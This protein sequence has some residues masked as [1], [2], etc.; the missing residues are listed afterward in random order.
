LTRIRSLIALSACVALGA[1][2]VS[3]GGDGG[4]DTTGNAGP[5]PRSVGSGTIDFQG[6]FSV[7]QN[8]DEGGTVELHAKGP[9][10]SNGAGQTPSFDLDISGVYSN[11]SSDENYR[12][13][14]GL[15]S[16]GE[17]AFVNFPQQAPGEARGALVQGGDYE[18]D[19]PLVD[20]LR[21]KGGSL[22]AADLIALAKDVHSE[23]E[24]TIDGVPTVH[25]SG[26]FD[27]DRIV[28]ALDPILADPEGLGLAPNQAIRPGTRGYLSRFV[29]AAGFDIYLGK[30]DGF[31]RRFTAD[32]V[33]SG[34]S[35]ERVQMDLTASLEEVNEPQTI[36]APAD[37]KPFIDLITQPYVALYG[38]IVGI[39]EA[40]KYVA[41]AFDEDGSADPQKCRELLAK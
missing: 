6:K 9:F 13:D 31:P 25:L 14:F 7:V 36:E 17:E 40:Q 1:V 38:S 29:R 22:T 11:P 21:R 32:I 23:G 8:G 28:K 34:V 12:F 39:P 10:E 37:P 19:S 26:Q 41:C 30:Q 16:T 2:L 27:L 20:S 18:L 3:C 33:L 15:T 24:V 4:K 5:E 35:V